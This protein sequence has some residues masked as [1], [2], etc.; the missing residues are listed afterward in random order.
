MVT[1]LRSKWA[2]GKARG[3]RISGPFDALSLAQG[4]R[5]ASLRSPF[6][7]YSPICV[8]WL[9]MSKRQRV[10]WLEVKAGEFRFESVKDSDFQP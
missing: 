6:H 2:V 8:G 4:I 5:R 7:V 1:S 10:E 3:G 9:A